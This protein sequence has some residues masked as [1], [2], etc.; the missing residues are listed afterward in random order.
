MDAC[1]ADNVGSSKPH[2]APCHK[3]QRA[4]VVALLLLNQRTIKW[5]GLTCLPFPICIFIIRITPQKFPRQSGS[6]ELAQIQIVLSFSVPCRPRFLGVGHWSKL[7]LTP[8]KA[9]FDDFDKRFEIRRNLLTTK[10]SITS[11]CSTLFLVQQIIIAL[12]CMV[13]RSE[14]FACK[15]APVQ[16]LHEGCCLIGGVPDYG[17]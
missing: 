9:L 7:R 17:V 2:E 13:P 10:S 16:I 8:L 11:N 12:K 3:G 15:F 5:N 1:K 4:A 14:R 6:S